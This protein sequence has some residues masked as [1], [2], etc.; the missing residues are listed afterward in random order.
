MDYIK[1][2]VPIKI[3]RKSIRAEANQMRFSPFRCF[4]DIESESAIRCLKLIGEYL[5]TK[6]QLTLFGIRHPQ[7]EGRGDLHV[8][9]PAPHAFGWGLRPL[10]GGDVRASSNFLTHLLKHTPQLST[11]SVAVIDD[12]K[13]LPSNTKTLFIGETLA[14]RLMS[15]KRKI[16]YGIEI[17][18]PEILMDINW[19]VIPTNSWIPDVNSIYPIDLPDIEFRHNLD[20][21]VI[22]SPARNLA[23]LPNG[24]AYLHNALKKTSINFQTFDLD[25]VTYHRYH[26]HRLFDRPEKNLTPG[27]HEMHPD[28]W[29][30]EA[31]D[32][33][34]KPDVI[35]YFRPIIDET[36]DKIIQAK[37]KILGLSLQECNV[38]F[39]R[40]VVREVKPRLPNT[41]ILVGG[42]SCYQSSIGRRAFPESDY[43]CIGE[44][45]LTVG[46]LV[47]ALAKGER[48]KDLPGILSRFDSPDYSFTNYPMPMDLDSLEM[49]KYDWTDIKLYRNYNNYQLTPIIASRGCR[50]SRCTFCAERFFWR[51]RDPKLVVDEFEYLYDQG[52]NLFMFNESDLNGLPEKVVA[53][54][55]E[56]IKR[57]LKIRLTGQL[58]I[59][60]KSDRAYFDKL[61]AGGF[62]ALRFGVDAWSTNSLRLQ[63]KGYTK[64]MI[65]QN[66]GDC[67]KA[68]INTEVN[69][70]IGIPG[71]TEAD[72]DESIELML[73]CNPYIGRHANMNTLILAIGSVYWEDPERFKIKFH[74]Y[75]KEEIFEKF[76]S[77]IP[78]DLWHSE[79]PY[80]DQTTRIQ[81]Y[82]RVIETLH[83]NSVDMGPF[84][85]EVFDHVAK[86]KGK[87]YSENAYNEHIESLEGAANNWKKKRREDFAYKVS[88]KPYTDEIPMVDQNLH[89]AK[90]DGAFWGVDSKTLE[91]YSNISL[92]AMYKTKSALMMKIVRER[93]IPLLLDYPRLK[94]HTRRAL[95]IIN[96]EG[97]SV[98]IKKIRNKLRQHINSITN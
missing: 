18:T 87:E 36:I 73:K 43:M 45:D 51:V 59:H 71:E 57:K 35:E 52:C 29:L 14:V 74:K 6:K 41:I 13:K 39:A 79:E 84:L 78:S 86:Q 24:L 27:G 47:E 8:E 37:P 7:A 26:I 1:K 28:P 50:W 90:Y 66:L 81:R 93:G 94:R 9:T 34:Q 42:F 40:A 69:T 67:Y 95:N 30:A 82:K 56:I 97:P 22:D 16:P 31:Y 85:K 10:A 38:R 21:L 2:T 3:K 88:S 49:A 17:V 92:F 77:F 60:K 70:V 54:C 83:N 44:A 68:G 89:I 11:H 55:D 72:I 32:Q 5:L 62:V 63:M 15:L 46:P 23:F 48:P 75:T 64:D 61:V 96:T 98:L 76:P 25:I 20:L 80:I 53:I 19:E 4:Q 58:R 65:Y 91:Y 33:W 12:I